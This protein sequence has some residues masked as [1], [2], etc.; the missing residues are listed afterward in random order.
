MNIMPRVLRAL[1]I[2]LNLCGAQTSFPRLMEKRKPL[3]SSHNCI[4]AFERFLPVAALELISIRRVV[5]HFMERVLAVLAVPDLFQFSLG[6]ERLGTGALVGRN[7]F[8]ERGNCVQVGANLTSCKYFGTI[9][10]NV[11]IN[12]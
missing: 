11:V 1:L 12:L 4:K 6:R 5:W 2:F 7:G 10:L 9:P 8:R 3:R